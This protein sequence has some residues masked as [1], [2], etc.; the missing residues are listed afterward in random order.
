MTEEVFIVFQVLG[1][2]TPTYR[3]ENL[4]EE[5]IQGTLYEPD[6]QK[7]DQAIYR[8]EKILRRRTRVRIKELY[9]IWRVYHA[10]FN[11]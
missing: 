6:L 9:V 7:T 3:L 5:E 1:T 4:N 10:E 8:I 2:Q 11:S